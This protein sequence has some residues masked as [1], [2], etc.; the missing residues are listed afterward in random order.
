M[1]SEPDAA[2]KLILAIDS[3]GRLAVRGDGEP[4]L[5]LSLIHI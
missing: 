1:T 2:D 5:R 3:R 4:V